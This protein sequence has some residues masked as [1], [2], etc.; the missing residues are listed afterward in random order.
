MLSETEFRRRKSS[1][2]VLGRNK[3]RR[4]GELWRRNASWR[5][6]C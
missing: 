3:A 6:Y 5:R 2:S 4:F 1:S